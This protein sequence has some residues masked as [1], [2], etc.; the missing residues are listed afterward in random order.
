MLICVAF[1]PWLPFVIAR[2]GQDVSYWRGALKLDEAIRHIFIN[3][4]M[5]ESVLENIAQYIAAGWLI[6]L[7]IGLIAL[8]LTNYKLQI[9]NTNHSL[10]FLILYLVVPLALLLF[11][12]SRN[13][14]FNARYLMIASPAF[15]LLLAAGLAHVSRITNYFLRFAF[16]VLPFIFLLL[17]SLYSV[18][19]AY[20]DPAFTKASFREV[21][22]YIEAHSAPDEAIILTSGHLFPA[23]NYY[24]RGNAPSV[25][26]P[27]DATLNADTCHRL[28]CDAR[29]ES[30][31]CRQARCLGC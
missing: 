23:F 11:L 1:L 3:F 26:L 6:V 25:R 24:Y 10:T 5:G 31:G 13:P 28:R 4:T 16:Y 18:A 20:F 12:F 8:A 9:R 14:K 29:V 17:T 19:N 30:N 21:A 7:L 27:D 2:F 15:L 22:Q